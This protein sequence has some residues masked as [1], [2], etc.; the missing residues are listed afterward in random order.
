[1][2]SLEPRALPN[3][4]AGF[5]RGQSFGGILPQRIQPTGQ[6]GNVRLRCWHRVGRNAGPKFVDEIEFLRGRAGLELGKVGKVHGS[7]DWKYE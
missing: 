5:F 4:G 7:T 2:A 6:L 3:T 1:M